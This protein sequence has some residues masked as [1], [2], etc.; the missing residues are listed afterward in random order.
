MCS[1]RWLSWGRVLELGLRFLAQFLGNGAMMNDERICGQLFLFDSLAEPHRKSLDGALGVD[2]DQVGRMRE[3]PHDVGR[4]FV[5]FIVR[6]DSR[7][8][9]GGANSG[10]F[11]A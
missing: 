8:T 11:P 9:K 3:V 1:N 6:L 5:E 7:L 10:T 4:D 2:E